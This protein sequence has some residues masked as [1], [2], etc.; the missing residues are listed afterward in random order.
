LKKANAEIK[1]LEKALF[2]TTALANA[3]INLAADVKIEVNGVKMSVKEAIA[4]A[5]EA[6]AK[7]NGATA[8]AEKAIDEINDFKSKLGQE[9]VT[10]ALAEKA[11][12]IAEIAKKYG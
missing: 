2:E 11:Y 4:L 10:K 6:T 9:K 12:K 5:N 3:A 8:K 1:K 7:A